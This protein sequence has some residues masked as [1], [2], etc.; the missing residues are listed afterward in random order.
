MFNGTDFVSLGSVTPTAVTTTCFSPDPVEPA[1]GSL[2]VT[3]ALIVVALGDESVSAETSGFILSLL[4]LSFA[5]SDVFPYSF[6]LTA[7]V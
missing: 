7:T 4:K 6:S 5:S 2:A 3:T 1:P